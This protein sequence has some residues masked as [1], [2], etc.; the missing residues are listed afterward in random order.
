MVKLD[1]YCD[2]VLSVKDF[3]CYLE[4]DRTHPFK[5]VSKKQ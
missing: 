3:S 5:S 1:W 2:T 4:H